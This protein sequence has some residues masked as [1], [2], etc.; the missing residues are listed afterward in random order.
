MKLCSKNTK[1]ICSRQWK[2]FQTDQEEACRNV[3]LCRREGIQSMQTPSQNGRTIVIN[4][5]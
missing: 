4:V 1:M 5:F 3:V 2:R